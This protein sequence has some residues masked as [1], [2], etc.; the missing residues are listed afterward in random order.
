MKPLPLSFYQSDNVVELAQKLLGKGLFTN[1]GAIT[2]GIIV[3]TEAYAGADDRASHAYAS[4][5]TKRNEVMYGPGGRAYVYL[6]YG[7]YNLFNA[8]TSRKNTPHA[9]LIRAIKPTIGID[10]MMQRRNQKS[11]KQNLCNGP[12]TLCQ[13]LGITRE[14]NGAKLDQYPIVICDLLNEPSRSQILAGPRIG[15]DYAGK[16]ALLPYRFQLRSGE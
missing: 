14:Q 4:K 1:F 2:G 10:F 13:A 11:L 16:D 15:V 12:G 6:C 5:R 7:M 8:V 3:E 9:I